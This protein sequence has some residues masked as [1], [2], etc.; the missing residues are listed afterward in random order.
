M[1]F[2]A[3]STADSVDYSFW[4]VTPCRL[5]SQHFGGTCCLHLQGRRVEAAC[6]SE[7]VV[8]IYQTTQV[9]FQRTIIFKCFTAF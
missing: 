4:D 5:A 8:N 3:L 6:S 7:T 9:A 2:E 1:K